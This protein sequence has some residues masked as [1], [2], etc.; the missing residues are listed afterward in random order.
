[1]APTAC[2]AAFLKVAGFL[3]PVPEQLRLII[4]TPP[5][6]LRRILA[7]LARLLGA[8]DL[9]EASMHEAE[10]I[11]THTTETGEAMPRYRVA[12]YLPR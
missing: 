12:S 2:H 1:M 4:E 5:V 6:G 7:T 11:E 10:R 3:R 9:A 8:L